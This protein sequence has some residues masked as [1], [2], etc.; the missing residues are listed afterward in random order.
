[1]KQLFT[2]ALMILA[3][4][5]ASCKKE[6]TIGKDLTILCE[7]LKPLSFEK[8]GVLNGI[9]VDICTRIMQELK[10]ENTIT[11]TSNW[12]SIF[13]LLK[14]QRQTVLFT[15]GLTTERK[16]QFKWVGPVVLWHNAF[17]S[18]KS[19][20]IE[21]TDLEDAR[22]LSA[23]GVVESDYTAEILTGLGF[24][25]LLYYDSY[26]VLIRN[27]YSGS[28]DVIFDERS[29]AQAAAM[30]LSLDPLE[31]ENLL[32]YNSTPGYLAFS[33]DVSDK[34]IRTW[35]EKLD[36]LK[37]NGY[38]QEVYDTYLPGTAAP[39]RILMFTEENP[40]QNYRDMGGNLTGSSVEMLKTMMEGTNLDGPVE[41]TSWANAYSQILLVPNSMTF[42]TLRSAAR[43][44]LFHWVGPVAKKRYCFYVQ[45]SSDY[46]IATID[47]ARHM[48]SVGTVAGW[49]SEKELLDLGFNNVVT[50][51]TP[52]EVF[53]KLMNGDIPCAVLND[54]AVRI[55]GT[56][57][58]NPPKNYRKEAILSEGQTYLAFS[59]DTDPAYITSWENAYNSLVSTGKLSEIWKEWYPD[60]DW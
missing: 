51:A 34:V 41:I 29:F 50:W 44:E 4:T 47:D 43:E 20:G 9:T 14:T 42:S 27:L 22:H 7:V 15:T 46:H 57:S 48:R 40:P 45:G 53:L 19:T 16:A 36:L 5:F 21:L 49:A 54:I 38:V 23:I 6:D 13:S 30:D 33:N 25:N 3:T 56:E 2:I 35:Q 58:G 37:D 10:L 24:T 26:E 17:I 52:Q 18:L 11:I 55:L 12:D 60:I 28:I 31:M 39:G 32:T 1:M 8:N 59:I